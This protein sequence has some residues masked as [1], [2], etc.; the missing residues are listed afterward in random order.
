[1]PVG[2]TGKPAAHTIADDAV[3]RLRSGQS[4]RVNSGGISAQRVDID[5]SQVSLAEKPNWPKLLLK[6]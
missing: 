2:E 1:V 6:T 5:K 3:N 4:A